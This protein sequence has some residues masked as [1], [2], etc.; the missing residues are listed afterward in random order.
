MSIGVMGCGAWLVVEA[1]WLVGGVSDGMVNSTVT[2][3]EV[4]PT[5]KTKPSQQIKNI[6]ES[7]E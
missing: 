6:S 3:G 7:K 2:K 4:L 5:N 1:L